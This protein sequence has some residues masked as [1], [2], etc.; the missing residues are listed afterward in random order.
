MPRDLA[1]EIV[2]TLREPEPT[3]GSE[4]W[5]LVRECKPLD[6]NSM[7]CN[8]IQCDHFSDTCVLAEIEGKPVGWVSG[9]VIPSDP[10]TLFI[11]QVAVS[12]DARGMGLGSLMLKEALQREACADVNK[13][14]TTITSDNDA[15]WALFRKF[16]EECGTDLDTEAYYEKDEH[17]NGQSKTENLVTIPL[18]EELAKVA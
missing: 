14:Q 2:P 16:A 8:L 9:H 5:E 13:I 12:E 7:Y 4:I 1:K 11:W 6:E 17:F 3:D 10:E 18:A 15:S